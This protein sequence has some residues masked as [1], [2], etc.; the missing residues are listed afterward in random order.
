MKLAIKRNVTR[1]V[2]LQLRGTGASGSFKI[3]KEALKSFRNQVGISSISSMA[4]YA[5]CSN[6]VVRNAKWKCLV[7]PCFKG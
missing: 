5:G 4:V 7:C 3:N 6:A 1:G 2:L